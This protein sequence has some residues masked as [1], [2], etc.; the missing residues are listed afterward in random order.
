M[1]TKEYIDFYINDINTVEK[2][3]ILNK[4]KKFEKKLLRCF[5]LYS[6]QSGYE[7]YKMNDIDKLILYTL[8]KNKNI[9]FS[10]DELLVII[11][12]YYKLEEIYFPVSIFNLNHDVL[13][14]LY[15]SNLHNIISIFMNL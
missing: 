12:G 14:R 13:T 8:W 9:Y 4:I 5:K 15:N 11:Y 2:I 1:T 7:D 3:N 10:I 6:E